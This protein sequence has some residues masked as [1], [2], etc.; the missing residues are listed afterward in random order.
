MQDEA[1]ALC[2]A[3]LPFQYQACFQ[4]D[5]IETVDVPAATHRGTFLTAVQ[6]QKTWFDQLKAAP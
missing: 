6:G 1:F 4:P 3:K 2:I 5:R